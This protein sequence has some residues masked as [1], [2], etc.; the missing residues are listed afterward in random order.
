MRT[1]L[2]AI[3]GLARLLIGSDLEKKQMDLVKSIKLSADHLLIMLNDILDVSKMEYDKLELE[4]IPFDLHDLINGLKSILY[5]SVTQKGLKFSVH[6]D[7]KLPRTL[8]GDPTRLTQVL[9]LLSNAEKFTKEGFVEL[10]V[11]II[12][13]EGGHVR[14]EFK[15][16]DSGIGISPENKDRIFWEFVQENK[17]TARLYGGTGLGLSIVKQLVELQ[18]GVIRLESSPN[19]RKFIFVE[20]GY[21]ID[22]ESLF[23]I[24]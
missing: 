13:I 7:S 14:I 8:I 12:Q 18:K 3:L 20:L 1:P 6:I 9:N 21:D 19:Q 24:R 5:Q 11:N 23:K 17:D 10:H 16:S 4:Y 22:K 15:V 2:T